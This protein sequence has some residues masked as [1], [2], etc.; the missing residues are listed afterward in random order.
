MFAEAR[1]TFAL[2]IISSM[3]PCGHNSI[4]NWKFKATHFIFILF[5]LH[6]ENQKHNIDLTASLTFI[7]ALKPLTFWNRNAKSC[8]FFKGCFHP[9]GSAG[10][11]KCP[12]VNRKVKRRTR[13]S[14]VSSPER[15][16][17][18]S[19]RWVRTHSA[20]TST[21]TLFLSFSSIHRSFSAPPSFQLSA[22]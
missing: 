1:V 20:F 15:S 11:K 22:T 16:R 5:F 10:V 8:C 2:Q 3:S 7:L 9:W 12:S 17:R 19:G 13:S 21:L 6:C 18:Q 14:A 4:F